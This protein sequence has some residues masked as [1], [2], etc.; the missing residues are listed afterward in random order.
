MVVVEEAPMLESP[1]D[2]DV[3]SIRALAFAQADF[4]PFVA[5]ILPTRS[6]ERLTRC[7]WAEAGRS[8]RPDVGSTGYRLTN[9]GWRI[10][11]ERWTRR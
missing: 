2:E 8:C 6:L 10:A 11:R 3:R 5:E 9:E 7:G 4:E 1:S